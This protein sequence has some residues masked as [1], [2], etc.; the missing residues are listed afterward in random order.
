MQAPGPGAFQFVYGVRKRGL[1][2]LAETLWLEYGDVFQVRIGAR[3][4]LFAMHP[5]AVEQVTNTHRSKYDKVAS[6]TPV[7]KYLTGEGLV[8]STGELW[9]RQRKL[10]APFFTPKA[11]RAYA[12]L[13]TRDAVRL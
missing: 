1:L 4:L 13:M 8:G 11:V 10:M 2:E 6:Y 3:T 9:R 5:D 7:R 12:E